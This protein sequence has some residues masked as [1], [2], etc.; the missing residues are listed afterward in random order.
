MAK[1]KIRKRLLIVFSSILILF[2][3]MGLYFGVFIRLHPPDI[4]DKSALNAVRTMPDK[5]FYC[6]DSCWLKKSETGLWEMYIQGKPFERGVYAGKLCKE[7]LKFQEDVFFK[8]INQLVPSKVFL[9]ILKYFIYWFNRNIDKHI[10]K[11]YLEEIY[12]LS[13]STP[14]EY[15]FIGNGYERTLN[16]HAAHD[17]G[18]ALQDYKIVGCT[19]FAAW[20]DK[21]SDS[22]LIIGRNFDFYA[23]DEFSKNKIVCFFKP[24]SGYPFMY[25]GWAGMLGAVSGMNM[26]GLTVS[27]NAAKSDVPFTAY[28]PISLLAREILQYAA[29]IPQAIAIAKSRQTFVSE[30]IL[31]GSASEKTVAIIEKSPTKIGIV[32]PKTNYQI[33]SNYFQSDEFKNDPLNIENIKTAASYYRYQRVEELIHSSPKLSVDNVASILRNKEG[34]HNRNI[35]LGNEKAINQLI[36]HHSVIFVPEKRLVWVSTAPFQLGCYIPYDLNKIFSNFAP[37][38]KKQEIYEKN[39]LIPADTFLYS[40]EYLQFLR[41]KYLGAVIRKFT[42][43]KNPVML[44]TAIV[45]YFAL[46]NPEYFSTYVTLGNFFEMNKDYPKAIEYYEKSLTKEFEKT[47]DR[48]NIIKKIHQIKKHKTN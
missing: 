45:Q 8:Q 25:V 6:I 36:A 48:D 16:Y 34:L 33:C 32:Y 21:T 29:N 18:H 44:D 46:Q 37:L 47:T 3:L 12:G 40:K 42:K 13:L 17:I 30:S 41:Y 43:E 4:K 26:Q 38:K 39:L 24:D 20:N 15:E 1:K 28:T 19:S 14:S 2:L 35:G 11:E 23:G 7:L 10:S 27:I 22:T 31:I 9:R 5:D